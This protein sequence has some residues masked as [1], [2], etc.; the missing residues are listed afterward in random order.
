MGNHWACTVAPV[1]GVTTPTPPNT[2][3]GDNITLRQ[4]LDTPK[5]GVQLLR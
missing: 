4:K 5:H 1:P 3:N 2:K